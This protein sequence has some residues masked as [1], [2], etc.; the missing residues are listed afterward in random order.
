MF[1]FFQDTPQIRRFQLPQTL[2]LE[3]EIHQPFT[4]HTLCQSRTEALALHERAPSQTR[5]SREACAAIRR[6][7]QILNGIAKYKGEEITRVQQPDCAQRF[8]NC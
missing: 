5:I 4:R 7:V 8:K 2:I 1:G 3:I 6:S